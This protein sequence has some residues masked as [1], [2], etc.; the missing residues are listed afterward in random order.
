M[1]DKE[2]RVLRP[3]DGRNFENKS[4]AKPRTTSAKPANQPRPPKSKN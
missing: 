3:Q 1:S 4:L 2:T